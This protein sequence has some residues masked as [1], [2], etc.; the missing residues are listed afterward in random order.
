[1]MMVVIKK[2]H[3]IIDSMGRMDENYQKISL[4]KG[5][6]CVRK[7]YHEMNTQLKKQLGYL[8]NMR[9][10]LENNERKNKRNNTQF[11]LDVMRSKFKKFDRNIKTGVSKERIELTKGKWNMY[12]GTTIR[13]YDIENYYRKINIIEKD[14]RISNDILNEKTICSLIFRTLH[15]QKVKNFRYYS[16]NQWATIVGR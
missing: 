12:T 9:W 11:E 4:F 6:N 5:D 16:V 15:K 8:Q 2:R 1:M 3:N 7:D 10:I 14:L 13:C